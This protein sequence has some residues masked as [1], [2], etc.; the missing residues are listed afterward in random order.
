MRKDNR[1]DYYD[2]GHRDIHSNDGYDQEINGLQQRDSSKFLFVNPN[3]TASGDGTTISTAYKTFREAIAF[4]RALSTATLKKGYTIYCLAGLSYEVSGIV[5][6]FD[7][8]LVIGPGTSDG[9]ILIGTG[10]AGV[11]DAATDHLLKISGSKNLFVGL[12]LYTYKDTKAAV[13]LGSATATD[14][15]GSFNK[16]LNCY[17]SKQADGDDMG[18]GAYIQGA[19][20]IEFASCVFKGCKSG[21]VMAVNSTIRGADDIYISNCLIVSCKYGLEMDG[22]GHDIVMERCRVIDGTNTG[23]VLTKCV[24]TT[25]NHATGS[26]HL[27]NNMFE[28]TDKAASFTKTGAGTIVH[29][30]NSYIE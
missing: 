17:L 22:D 11:L 13:Y 28:A 19:N 1:S 7:D 14:F 24:M 9:F 18:F 12:S 29:A 15:T 20:N 27:L 30:G 10:T 2:K 16:F 23:E 8:L 6:D 25:A 26:I 21:A 5:I 3:I 4:I